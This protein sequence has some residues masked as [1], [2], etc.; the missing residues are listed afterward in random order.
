MAHK[1]YTKSKEYQKLYYEKNKQAVREKQKHYYEYNKNVVLERQKKY[2]KSL[3]REAIEKIHSRQKIY[4]Q[5][6]PEKRIVTRV[7]S[8]AKKLNIDFNL[9]VEDIKIPTQCPIL[10]IPIYKI[11]GVK[12]GPK[13]NSPSVDR[14]DNTKGYVKGN[15]HIISN[16][17]NV[18]KN[19]ASP[20]E[21][22][23]F[24]FWVLLTYGHLIDEKK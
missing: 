10:N 5:T 13:D 4:E 23:Q 16:K 6:Y 12:R 3:P 21:L 15:V 20:K 14:F 18:M 11:A 24:A 22:L 19:S 8:R 1:E 17:A 2:M 9:G 7:K